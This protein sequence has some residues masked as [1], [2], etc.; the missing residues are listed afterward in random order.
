MTSQVAAPGAE[1]AVYDCLVAAVVAWSVYMAVGHNREPYKRIQE[2]QLSP[3]DRA[4]RR[5]S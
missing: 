1:S 4:M 5:V 3:R 2:A